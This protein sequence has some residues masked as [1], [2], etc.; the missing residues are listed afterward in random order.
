MH[1]RELCATHLSWHDPRATRPSRLVGFGARHPEAPTFT[2]SRIQLCSKPPRINPP[3]DP[4]K[5]KVFFSKVVSKISDVTAATHE[6]GSREAFEAYRYGSTHATETIVPASSSAKMYDDGTGNLIRKDREPLLRWRALSTEQPSIT[7]VHD[8]CMVGGDALS[9]FA[10]AGRAVEAD[11]QEQIRQACD[12]LNLQNAV[13]LSSRLANLG[14]PN[15]FPTPVEEYAATLRALIT[16]H[17]T[18]ADPP[19][20]LNCMSQRAHHLIGALRQQS[21]RTIQLCRVCRAKSSVTFVDLSDVM[22]PIWDAANDWCHPRGHV[23]LAHRVAQALRASSSPQHRR[24]SQTASP[25]AAPEGTLR[26]L[27]TVLHLLKVA[28]RPLKIELR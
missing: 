4:R 6:F 27:K 23:A 10:P 15:G 26:N 9:D 8:V 11:G 18:S 21:T 3:P 20:P 5:L 1:C 24:L 2:P 25:A 14:W 19:V 17:F 28:R 7:P 16:A 22:G 13:R 12:A